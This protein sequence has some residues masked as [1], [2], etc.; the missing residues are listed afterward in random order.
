MLEK[1]FPGCLCPHAIGFPPRSRAWCWNSQ[2]RGAPPST[3]PPAAPWLLISG[4]S[5][6]EI[7]LGAPLSRTI[8]PS[9]AR[10]DPAPL[11]TC[12]PALPPSPTWP[13]WGGYPQQIPKDV[14]YGIAWTHFALYLSIQGS[15]AS[16]VAA[17]EISLGIP[18]LCHYPNSTGG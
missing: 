17:P 14:S 11:P 10:A 18:F 3:W 12:N 1:P 2:S 13:L 7:L 15:G 9:T 8:R 4:A 5:P 16:C 6:K